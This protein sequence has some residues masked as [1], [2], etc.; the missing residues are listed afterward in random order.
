[1]TAANQSHEILTLCRALELCEADD[2]LLRR[3]SPALVDV[4]GLV[5][6]L[7]LLGEN[8]EESQL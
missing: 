7:G 1:M 8:A 2:D 5:Q 6:K 4:Y 3:N